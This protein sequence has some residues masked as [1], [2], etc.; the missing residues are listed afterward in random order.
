PSRVEVKRGSLGRSL[1]SPV[2]P[3]FRRRVSHPLD[4]APFLHPAHRTGR[5]RFRPPAL[6]QGSPVP[7][8]RRLV[9]RGSVMASE[10]SEP[11]NGVARLAPISRLSAP[12]TMG[13]ELRPLCS[14]GVTRLPRSYGPLRHLGRPDLALAGCRLRVTRPHR[15]GFPCGVGSPG[16]GRPPPRHRW[17]P[18]SVSR[19]EGWSPPVSR[20]DGLPRVATGS[21]ST[22]PCFG[23]GTAVPRRS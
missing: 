7:R 18:G 20:D 2:G 3:P 16:A 9:G 14:A 8:P 6:G 17:D 15:R 19:R 4:H 21:A 10:A 11:F 5:A 13:L 22:S 1:F 23:A 12:L